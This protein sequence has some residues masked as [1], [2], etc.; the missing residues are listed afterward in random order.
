MN[1]YHE[2]QNS[3]N[4]RPRTYRPITQLIGGFQSMGVPQQSSK[5]LDP[6]N[7][8]TQGFGIF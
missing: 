3:P 6:L 4:G 1:I 5:S 7:I 2:A 8:E